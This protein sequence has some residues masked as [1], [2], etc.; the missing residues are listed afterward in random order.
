MR[1]KNLPLVLALSLAIV[2]IMR[3]VWRALLPAWPGYGVKAYIRVNA[4]VVALT[5]VRVI[6]GTG[7]PPL[8]DFTVI[9]SGG[10]IQAI[11]SAATT[12]VPR[13]AEVLDLTGYKI[14]RAHV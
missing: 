7:A 3:P 11:G 9:L 10:R 4:P 5:H 13:G 8:E 12:P 2:L 14:G 1:R 6:D